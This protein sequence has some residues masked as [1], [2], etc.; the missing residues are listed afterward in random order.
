MLAVGPRV[1]VFEPL[2][3]ALIAEN[4]IPATIELHQI[5]AGLKIT[6]AYRAAVSYVR[7]V[8]CEVPEPFYSVSIQCLKVNSSFFTL[9]GPF[10]HCFHH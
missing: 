4:V 6:Q 2:G 5:V 7:L 9:Q 10:L 3:D 1:V 8:C